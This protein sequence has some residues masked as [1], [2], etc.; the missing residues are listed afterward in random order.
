M[1]RKR[2]TKLLMSVG[3]PRNTAN[4]LAAFK[5]RQKSYR[6]FFGLI[7]NEIW[8]AVRTGEPAVITLTVPEPMEC[9]E[10]RLTYDD[11]EVD[12]HGKD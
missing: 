8:R 3:L 2:F 11:E 10:L 9:L 6:E 7:C 5:S 12:S 4:H 1:T